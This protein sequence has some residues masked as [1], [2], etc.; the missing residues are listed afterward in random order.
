MGVHYI[1]NWFLVLDSS[2]SYK[3]I[4]QNVWYTKNNGQRIY[5]IAY[6]I[7]LIIKDQGCI[8]LVR[9][10]N[11]KVNHSTTEIEFEFERNLAIENEIARHYYELYLIKKK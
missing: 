2:E 8:A 11:F 7:P 5:P 4:A 9:I 3:E 10:L 6:E 1:I